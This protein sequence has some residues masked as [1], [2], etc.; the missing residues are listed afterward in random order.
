M[1]TIYQLTE[2]FPRDERFGLTSQ[3]RR[4]AISVPANIA[5]GSKR[6]RPRD[7]ARFLNIAE[8]SLAEAGYLLL[9]SRDLGHLSGADQAAIAEEID[10]VARMLN[11]LRR[12]VEDGDGPRQLSTLDC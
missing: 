9:L 10:Q 4:A 7:Y 11:A 8:G 6:R 3:L 12:K 1:M 2:R 5:E